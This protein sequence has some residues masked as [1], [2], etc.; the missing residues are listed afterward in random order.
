MEHQKL[1]IRW[2]RITPLAALHLI[3]PFLALGDPQNVAGVHSRAIDLDAGEHRN[4]R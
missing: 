1:W 4:P 3:D 2:R